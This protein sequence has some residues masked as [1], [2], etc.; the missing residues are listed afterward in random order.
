MTKIITFEVTPLF[1]I[2]LVLAITA[3]FLISRLTWNLVAKWFNQYP[4]F[5]VGW[6]CGDFVIGK[7]IHWYGW[8]PYELYLLLR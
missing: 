5:H 7:Y 3:G 8:E 2:L 1:V 4:K 6:E